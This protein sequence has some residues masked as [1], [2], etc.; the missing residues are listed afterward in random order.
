MKDDCQNIW[1]HPFTKVPIYYLSFFIYDVNNISTIKWGNWGSRVTE[2]EGCSSNHSQAFVTSSF[3]CQS[4]E[5]MSYCS[6]QLQSCSSRRSSGFASLP[7]LLARMVTILFLKT[8]GTWKF[9]Q[10]YTHLPCRFLMSLFYTTPSSTVI[11]PHPICT[12][13]S[14]STQHTYTIHKIPWISS[15]NTLKESPPVSS[16]YVLMAKYAIFPLSNRHQ[17]NRSFVKLHF[18]NTYLHP[19]SNA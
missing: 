3:L 13:L 5:D 17:L 9:C 8:K 7:G 15:L 16:D 12:G 18:W 6:S 4:T 10:S 11:T 2:T 19:L 1:V 14:L